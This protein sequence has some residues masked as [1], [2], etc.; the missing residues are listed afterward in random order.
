[1]KCIPD[2]MLHILFPW[3]SC[4]LPAGLKTRGTPEYVG[5]ISKMWFTD[6]RVVAKEV[7]RLEG[8]DEN[9]CESDGGRLLGLNEENIWR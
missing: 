2:C 7:W 4:S 5:S 1:M 8:I 3:R 6:S 9:L